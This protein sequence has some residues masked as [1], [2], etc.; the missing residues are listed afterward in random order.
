MNDWSTRITFSM[1]RISLSVERVDGAVPWRGDALTEELPGLAQ[2][3][4]AS[5]EGDEYQ[6]VFA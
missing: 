6:S 1:K 3:A 4:G 2:D 5:R